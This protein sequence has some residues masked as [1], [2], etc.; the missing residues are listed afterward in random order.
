MLE[1]RAAGMDERF[2]YRMTTWPALEWQQVRKYLDKI[3]R[4]PDVHL[5]LRL[6]VVLP[7]VEETVIQRRSGFEAKEYYMCK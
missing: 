6:N 7:H 4:K 2:S 1:Q 3:K 5:A